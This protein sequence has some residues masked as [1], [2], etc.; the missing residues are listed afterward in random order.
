MS[1]GLGATSANASAYG[2]QWFNSFSYKDFVIPTGVLKHS[3]DGRGYKVNQQVLVVDTYQI[4]NLEM[5]FSDLRNSKSV[6][7]VF[8]DEIKGC[9]Y[10][11]YGF[12][13]T[14]ERKI[15]KTA[16]KSCARAYFGG[17]LKVQQCHYIN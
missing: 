11:S 3:I 10:W 6:N 5:R 4:C 1:L 2:E 14:G 8:F 16:Q 17:S 13:A 9:F 12:A 7:N 15:P